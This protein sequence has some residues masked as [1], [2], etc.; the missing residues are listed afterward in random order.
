[1]YSRQHVRGLRERAR[2]A[3]YSAP[4]YFW[5]LGVG[6][7]RRC[8]NGIGPDRWSK[9]FRALVTRLLALF[10]TEA[11]I[12]DVEYTYQPKTYRH[13]TVAN[14]R[15]AYNG[16]VAAW[17][18]HGMF[19]RAFYRQAGA[20]ILLAVLCQLFGWSGYKSTLPAV[21]QQMENKEEA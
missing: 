6:K 3:A 10:E 17:Y 11:L 9:R 16:I 4:N 5:R 21:L 18:D 15:F 19:C 2:N 14:L 13:F 7:L 20:G 1:M 8:Y 12:H